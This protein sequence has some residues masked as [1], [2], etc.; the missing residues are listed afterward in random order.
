MSNDPD[1]DHP[2]H[3]SALEKERE[4]LEAKVVAALDIMNCLDKEVT[5]GLIVKTKCDLTQAICRKAELDQG[6]ANQPASDPETDKR[7]YDTIAAEIAW[8]SERLKKLETAASKATCAIQ[9]TILW[10]LDYSVAMNQEL[11]ETDATVLKCGLEAAKTRK[12]DI[13]QIILDHQELTP[14]E[15]Y[16]MNDI[17]DAEIKWREERL[18]EIEGI[19][20][21]KTRN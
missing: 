13:A 2:S 1:I 8:H 5:K 21:L 12:K 19:D 18:A 7:S 10:L 4:A 6:I 14:E 11:M 3:I 9:K 16:R 17:I 20:Y 15:T